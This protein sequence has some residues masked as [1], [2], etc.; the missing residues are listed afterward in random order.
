MENAELR[1]TKYGNGIMEVEVWKWKYGKASVEMEVRKLK[2]GTKKKSRLSVS[3]VLLIH[4][5][6]L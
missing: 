1:K 3:S 5:C 4:N 6:V 2:Y